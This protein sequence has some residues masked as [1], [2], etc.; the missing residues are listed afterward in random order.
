MTKQLLIYE[1]A[2]PVSK[3]RHK[4]LSVKTGADYRFAGEVNSL[5]LMAIEF[6]NAAVEYPVV[7]AGTEDSVMPAVI[8]GVRDK[9]NLYL[10]KDGTWEARYIP[11][12]VRRYPFV[13]SGSDDG[14]TFTLC[15]DETFSGC[16]KEGRGERLFD[17]AGEQSQYLGSILTFLKD[18]QAH[19]QRTQA[20]CKKVQDLD[21]LEPMRAQ[22]T[23]N[24]GEQMAL[25][26]FMAISR[27]RLKKLTGDQLADLARTDELELFYLH[28]QSM[29]NFR[30]M[31]DR[32]APGAAVEDAVADS[33]AAP[34][35]VK[36]AAADSAAAPAAARDTKKPASGKKKGG[37]N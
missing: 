22:I 18:Y 1:R 12:F 28:M 15:I 30:A 17:A 25:Q 34:P 9:E 26:G 20:F 21:L 35:A 27:E 19:F 13:F 32:V 3:E 37:K 31:I 33:A 14:K 10:K 11:A 4:D 23:L 7:F 6:R 16:N 36:E 29:M 24:T 5:P 2:V 8:L